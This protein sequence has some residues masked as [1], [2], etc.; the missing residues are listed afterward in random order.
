MGWLEDAYCLDCDSQT[1]PKLKA[2]G[3]GWTMLILLALGILPGLL[4]I[5][6]RL[7]NWKRVCALCGSSNIVPV[8]SSR[9]QDALRRGPR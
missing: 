5:L 7:T 1:Y 9:A 3:S 2:R 8:N 4:F 6:W